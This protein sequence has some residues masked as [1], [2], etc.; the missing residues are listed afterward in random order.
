M[1]LDIKPCG[2]FSMNGE[3][4]KEKKGRTGE[5]RRVRRDVMVSLAAFVLSVTQNNNVYG[6]DGILDAVR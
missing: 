6:N 3:A 1:A 4:S 5:V 2:K